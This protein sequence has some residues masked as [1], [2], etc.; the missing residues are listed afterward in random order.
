MSSSIPHSRKG[1]AIAIETS[2][3]GSSSSK[4]TRSGGFPSNC[5]LVTVEAVRQASQASNRRIRASGITIKDRNTPLR[6]NRP[7]V[8]TSS[9]PRKTNKIKKKKSV[10]HRENKALD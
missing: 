2:S 1:K 5:C 3:S 9:T 8:N 4:A 10:P 6:L 7:T